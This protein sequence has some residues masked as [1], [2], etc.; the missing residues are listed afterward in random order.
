MI[1]LTN[2][3]EGHIGKP[4]ALNRTLIE[5]VYVVFEGETRVQMNGGEQYIVSQTYDEVLAA[6]GL[7][8][9]ND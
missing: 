5:A 7:G 3:M 4:L 2:S 1:K 8:L 9:A 6:I